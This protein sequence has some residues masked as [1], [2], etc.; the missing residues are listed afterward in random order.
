VKTIKNKTFIRAPKF[1]CALM[2]ILLVSSMM[3]S[4]VWAKK[5]SPPEPEIVNYNIW[6]GE[7]G[8]H[9]ILMDP[10]YLVVE[11]VEGGYW[12]PPPTKVKEKAQKER[13]WDITLLG[14]EGDNCGNYIIAPV[15]GDPHDPPYGKLSEV[16][17]KKGVDVNLGALYFSIE[18][19]H[20]RVPRVGERD[21]W[22]I[23]IGWQADTF[24]GI[25]GRTNIDAEWE[26]EYEQFTDTDKWTVTFNEA[27]FGVIENDGSGEIIELWAGRLSFTVEIVRTLGVS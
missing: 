13:L 16:L 22:L 15:D 4:T 11:D 10:G 19:V 24:L 12:L 1:V 6:I 25:V 14:E 27:E 18:H 17:A 3:R 21:Y 23:W 7:T 8:E 2:L 20:T 26:G 9:I 5:P